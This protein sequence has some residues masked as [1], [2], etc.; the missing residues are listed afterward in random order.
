MLFTLLEI[1]QLIIVI[2]Q[3]SR[4]GVVQHRDELCSGNNFMFVIYNPIED[5]NNFFMD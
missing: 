3:L 4:N 1:Q 5:I 2:T